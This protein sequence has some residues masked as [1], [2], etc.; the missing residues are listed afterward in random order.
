MSAVAQCYGS[1]ACGCPFCTGDVYCHHIIII[2]EID[3]DVMKNYPT[4]N[5]ILVAH[6]ARGLDWLVRWQ[7]SMEWSNSQKELS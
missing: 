2:M 7:G 5:H 6:G 4:I 3:A 1:F